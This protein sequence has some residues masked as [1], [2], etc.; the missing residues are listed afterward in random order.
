MP[1]LVW[2]A[3]CVCE[4]VGVA[5]VDG[6]RVVLALAV[7]VCVLLCVWLALVVPVTV[8]ETDAERVC[9]GVWVA[10]LLCACEEVWVLLSVNL[11]LPLCV[12]D[13]VCA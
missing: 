13:A 5:V 4:P 10:E 9:E 7:S 3:V 12:C 6:V 11:W 1:E 2:D 8:A